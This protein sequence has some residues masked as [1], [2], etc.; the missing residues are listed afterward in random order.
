MVDSYAATA[1]GAYA[2]SESYLYTVDAF[3]LYWAKLAADGFISVTRWHRARREL[4]TTRMALMMVDALRREGVPEPLRHLVIVRGANVATI[5]ITRRALSL[6]RYQR[7]DEID[8]ERGFDRLWPPDLRGALDSQTT[9]VLIDVNPEQH[10]QGTDL[11][12]PT[13]DRPFFFQTTPIFVDRYTDSS[14]AVGMLRTLSLGLS[15]AC[16]LLFF[17]PLAL[18]RV[19]FDRAR[20]LRG[21][22]Y[23]IAIGLGFMFVEAPIIQWFV[24]FLGHP[25]FATTVVICAL[26]AGAGLGSLAAGKLGLAALHKHRLILPAILVLLLCVAPWVVR[27]GLALPLALRIAITAALLVPSGFAMGFAFPAGM[28]SFGHQYQPWFWAVNGAASVMG[29]VLSLA[30]ALLFGFVFT[31]SCGVVAYLVA[32]LVLSGPQQ[33]RD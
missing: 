19:P 14:Q 18:R 12:P 16:G 31:I 24:L 4:E 30:C 20:G 3:R 27:T 8:R 29:S 26:L 21:A 9:Q 5:V 22:V 11:S 23:F 17:L 33:L 1:A 2:L 7:L 6:E 25:S 10:L 32:C 13:D 15:L 28:F